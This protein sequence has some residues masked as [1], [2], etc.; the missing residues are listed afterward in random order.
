MADCVYLGHSIRSGQVRPE[1][2]TVSAVRNCVQPHTSKQ[3]YWFLGLTGYY[4]KFIRYATLALPL[5]DATRKDQPDRVIWSGECDRA[6]QELKAALCDSPVLMS[7]NFSKEFIV[8]SDASDRGL[9]AVLSQLDESGNNK[10]VA[11]TSHKLLPREEKYSMVEKECLARWQC[12]PF[13]C[14][15]WADTSVYIQTDHHCLEWLHNVKTLTRWSL[16]LQSYSFMI[17]YRTGL[18]NGNADGLSRLP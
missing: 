8:Q 10:P 1:E 13:T 2:V 11:Y 16:F 7:P 6:F 5:T 4:R 17:Q 3:V 12:R 18:H 14:P 15:S 9:G